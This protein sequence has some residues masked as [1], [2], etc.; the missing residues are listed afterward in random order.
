[1]KYIYQ[2]LEVYQDVVYSTSSRPQITRKKFRTSRISKEEDI[3][4]ITSFIETQP[5]TDSMK[6]DFRKNSIVEQ[7]YP[8]QSIGRQQKLNG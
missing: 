3:I 6:S 5:G 8:Q 1:M 7:D 2:V 4:E